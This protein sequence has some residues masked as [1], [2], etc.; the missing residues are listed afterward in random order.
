MRLGDAIKKS[1]QP[2]I[3]IKVGRMEDGESVP[4]VLEKVKKTIE[5][6]YATLLSIDEGVIYLK[7]R[8]KGEK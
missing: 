3:F 8:K 2:E 1:F 5:S 4:K 6:E 7:R